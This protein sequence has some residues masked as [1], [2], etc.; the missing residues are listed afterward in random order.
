MEN[1]NEI[2]NEK[3]I[4]IVGEIAS[5]FH[6]AMDIENAIMISDKEK[7]THYFKGKEALQ[8]EIVGDPI[9]SGGFIPV[10]LRT[11]ALQRNLIPKEV[12]GAAFKSS[13]IPVKDSRGNI[14]GTITVALSLKNQGS[15]QE[16]T[17]NLSSSAEQLSATTQEMASS[18]MLLSDDASN[19]LIQTQDI[20]E[21]VEQTNSIL[22]FVNKV[23]SDSNLL[24]LNAAIEAARAGD[25]GKGFSVVANEIRKMAENSTKS[26]NDTK[27]LISSIRSKA[28]NLLEKTRELSD[29]A[30][31]QAAATQEISASIQTLSS[32]VQ[33][34]EK[35]SK[36]V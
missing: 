25:L 10:A 5:L 13:T 4:E 30:Q 2:S 24:G 33:T 35:I 7:F 11:G 29:V 20:L 14:I 26:V 27:K 8:N 36:V 19:L 21:L 16:V 22:D 6:D 18:A 9:P 1:H 17:E 32:N 28:N 34:V 3:Y 15:L 12:Y 23:A 31:T